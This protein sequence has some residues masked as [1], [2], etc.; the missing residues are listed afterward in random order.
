MYLQPPN[1]GLDSDEDSDK[2]DGTD[3]QHLSVGQ[4]NAPAECRIDFGSHVRES[5]DNE[6]KCSIVENEVEEECQYVPCSPAASSQNTRAR[7]QE[8]ETCSSIGSPE[9]TKG[10]DHDNFEIRKNIEGKWLSEQPPPTA[11]FKWKKEKNLK[12]KFDNVA[13]PQP[14]TLETATPASIFELFF[15][16]EVICFLVEMTNLYAQRDKG[17]HNFCTD[18][19]EIRLFIAMLLITGYNQLPRRKMYWKNAEDVLNPAMSN[20]MSRNRFEEL[21]SVLHLSDNMN[22][23]Q[24][25]KFAKVRPF[26]ELIAK[27]CY[28]NRPNSADLSV[29]ESMLPYYGRNNS[30]QRIQNKAV[31]SGYKMWVLAEPSGYVVTF[32]P[33]QG[34]KSGATR[35]NESTWGLGERVVLSLLDAIPQNTAYR[36]F[37]DNFFTSMRLLRFLAANNIRASGTVRENRIGKCPIASKK[38]IDKFKRGELDYRTTSSDELTIVG[39]KDNKSVYVASNCDSIEPMS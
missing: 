17:K 6:N 5:F 14:H 19:S 31:R 11:A 26:Y 22:L 36:V 32:D 39:W 7:N 3:I 8:V 2:E 9:N 33:Y 18:S 34:A 38:E 28:N 25:D 30:K 1:N 13:Q 20:A 12:E 35:A 10:H 4:L 37:M 16:E 23:A 21:L 27:R 15:D 29:D 24:N